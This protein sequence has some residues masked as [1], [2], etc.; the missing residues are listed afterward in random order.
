VST[1]I[2]IGACFGDEGKGHLVD[3]HAIESNG[4]V[5][6]FNGGSQARH[7]V[8]TID[9]KRHT[10]SHF[11]SGTFSK[12]DT[13]LSKHFVVNPILFL[14]EL[15]KIEILGFKPKVYIHPECIFTTPYDMILN[16]I[17]EEHRGEKRH[18]SCGVGVNETIE[19]NLKSYYTMMD[20]D[21][22]Y[23]AM[24]TLPDIFRG[25]TKEY[26]PK[27]LKAV[28]INKIPEKYINLIDNKN[29][30]KRFISDL[31]TFKKYI[32]PS[33][34]D[35]LK[36]RN[37]IFEG[38]QGLL[39]DEDHPFFPNVTRSKTGL[40]NVV[41][42]AKIIGLSELD[43][44]Y[45]TRCYITRHGAGP[46]PNEVFKL[47]YKNI[48][49]DTNLTNKYQG[50]LR[51]GI[52]DLSLLSSTINRDLLYSYGMKKKVTI[53]VTC[54]DQIDKEVHYIYKGNKLCN[55]PSK[56]FIDDLLTSTCTDSFLISTG[57]TKKD[58]KNTLS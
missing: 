39:L 17:I 3:Y 29:I 18:G 53:A 11:G 10:F 37:L 51:F 7:T 57:K 26:I 24:K 43:I 2:V 22:L 42:I 46:F 19:R 58:I 54:L 23:Y 50:S 6:R 28:G 13:F 9:G 16:Q 8:V 14:D 47:P 21:W 40:H 12:Y 20:I 36:D 52:L 38:A 41:E 48:V 31:E 1:K 34:Y 4:I 56:F 5:V 45:V 15:K 49:D 32:I 25:I 27:R 55:I 33:Y 30:Q 44:T 35:V